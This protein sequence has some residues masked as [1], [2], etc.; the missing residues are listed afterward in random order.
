MACEPVRAILSGIV[1]LCVAAAVAIGGPLDGRVE[2]L[3]SN[4]R[5]STASVAVS[6]IDLDSGSEIAAYN[7]GK[8]MIPASNMKVLTSGAAMLVLGESFAFRTEF[9]VVRSGSGTVLVIRGAGD[10]ALGDPAIFVDEE[11]TLTHDAL[12]DAIARALKDRGIDRVDEIV[13]DDRVFDREWAHPSWPA[14][15]LNRWYCAEVGGLNFQTNV[16][17]VYP[18]PGTPGSAPYVE[19]QP[20]LPWLKIAVRAKSINQGR[21]SAWVARP[22]PTNEFTLYGNVRGRTEIPVAI[23][24]PPTYAGEVI[25]LA[26]D[27]RGVRVSGDDVRRSV[28]L[29]RF[30][31]SFEGAETVAVVSTPIEDV[32]R[33]TNTKSHNLYAECLFKRIGHEVTGDAGSWENGASVMRLLLS[34]HLGAEAAQRTVIADGSGMSRDNRVSAETL[35]SWLRVLSKE[36][37]W[38]TYIG[39]FAGPGEGTLRSRFVDDS[40]DGS[41][42]AKSGYLNGVYALSGVIEH[43]RG[44]RV[45]FSIILNNVKPGSGSRY[46][47][48]LIDDIVLMLDDWASGQQSGY[49]G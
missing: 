35:T 32:L 6:A 45:A 3:V 30:D 17:N 11:Q 25:A 23:H 33:R 9:D 46:A 15:Q 31:E 37:G 29:A 21:D 47:K 12:F 39:T 40:T 24:E 5:L 18:I 26:L 36:D 49:G 20:E 41:L 43:E 4:S 8:S 14:D 42:R 38:D 10:P 44:R 13:V 1:S 22:T 34:E 16:L 7:A 2:S 27:A 19:T 28:R 48:P